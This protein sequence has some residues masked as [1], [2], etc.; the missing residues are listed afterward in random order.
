[1][2]P[3]HPI[4]AGLG[5]VL[6]LVG[7]LLLASNQQLLC[8]VPCV[9]GPSLLYIGYRPGR[10]SLIVFG[11]VCVTVGCFLATWGIYLLPYSEPKLAHVLGRPLFWGLF[12]IFGGICAI[13]HG[14][15]RCISGGRC[16]GQG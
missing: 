11:H 4:T 14:F 9:I 16:D 10:I 13:Y 1:M 15:C 8:L 2:M 7:L 3:K 6:V 12:A 5:L